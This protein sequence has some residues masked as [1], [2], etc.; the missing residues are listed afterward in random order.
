MALEEI[1]YKQNFIK[2]TIFKLEYEKLAIAIDDDIASKIM[3]KLPMYEKRVEKQV[4]LSMGIDAISSKSE[5]ASN[6]VFSAMNKISSLTISELL[7]SITFESSK[8]TTWSEYKDFVESLLVTVQDVIKDEKL[9]RIGLRFINK[10]PLK[11]ILE[12]KKYFQKD[13]NTCFLRTKDEKKLN[14]IF[15]IKEYTDDIANTRFQ[16]GIP[17]QYYPS[18]IISPEFV[19]DID[20]YSTRHIEYENII[21]SLNDFHLKIQTLF[22]DSITDK[23]RRLMGVVSNGTR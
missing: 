12:A 4:H 22:E 13:V 7:K 9:T 11:E 18:P 8:Y 6:H 21:M 23:L 19:I 1:C 5:V 3:T 10:I 15:I 20:I 2:S 14:R 16:F 17:N